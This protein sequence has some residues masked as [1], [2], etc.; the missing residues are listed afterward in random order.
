MKRELA[1]LWF[2]PFVALL[3]N[4]AACKSRYDGKA[5]LGGYCREVPASPECPRPGG[6]GGSGGMGG[7]GGAAGAPVMGSGGAPVMGEGGGGAG[8]SAGVGPC[9]SDAACAVDK[10]DGSLC[11]AGACTEAAGDCDPKVLVVADRADE[12]LASGEPRGA[13]FFR[14]L[15]PALTAAGAG[16]R[17][18]AY[19]ATSV[20]VP[21]PITVPAGVTLEGHM[22]GAGEAVPLEIAAPIAGSPL[23]TMAGGSGLEGFV[24]EGGGVARGIAASSGAVRLSGPLRVTYTALALELTGDAFATVH[25]TAAAPVV[26]AGNARGVDVA[27]DAGLDLQGD[28]EGGGMVIEAT[29]AGAGVLVR[30]GGVASE[31]RL[32]GLLARGNTGESAPNGA[33]AVEVRRGRAVVIAASV[34][35][36]NGVALT[37]NGEG[38][39]PG[40]AFSNV[41]IAENLFE[42]PSASSGTAICGARL[43]GETPLGLAAGNRFPSGLRSPDDCDD[44]GA[45]PAAGCDAGGDIGVRDLA[46]HFALTCGP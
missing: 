11:V 7:A 45:G 46:E 19:A 17:V 26:L 34:F 22:P 24:L 39:P 43:G 35:R 28:G 20:R 44:L 9:T 23:V 13:C 29:G 25:G 37:L 41:V 42:N 15:A 14:A 27:P 38:G 8:G 12:A 3:V 30:A 5:D 1:V 6:A 21:N 10:G 36:E 18:A 4:A 2:A 40:G 31:V 32:V 33:G 16:A